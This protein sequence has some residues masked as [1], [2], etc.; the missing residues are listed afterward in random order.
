MSDIEV[1]IKL[2]IA[3]ILGGL[4]GF[5]REK[6]GKAAGLRTHILVCVGSSL[7]TILSLFFAATFPY[8]DPTRIAS[9]VLI[10][11][12]FIG[13]GTIIKEGNGNIIGI[14]TAASIWISAAIGM[15]VGIGYYFAALIATLIALLVLNFLHELEKKYI[16]N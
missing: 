12:G 14:T 6:E 9:N 8:S 2:F 10:G 1:G 3:C 5:S 11:I 16:R 15:S 13:G 7:F 4:I